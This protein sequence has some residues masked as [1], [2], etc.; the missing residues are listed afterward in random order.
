MS[1]PVGLIGNQ[2]YLPGLSGTGF[3]APPFNSDHTGCP[4]SLYSVLAD[5]ATSHPA[6]VTKTVSGAQL[7]TISRTARAESGETTAV[8]SS[9]YF[10]LGDKSTAATHTFFIKAVACDSAEILAGPFTITVACDQSVVVPQDTANSGSNTFAVSSY[11]RLELVDWFTL[12][13]TTKYCPITQYGVTSD[14]TGP[15]SGARPVDGVEMDNTCSQ[16]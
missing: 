2:Q 6:F 11:G 4:V 8:A 5:N 14:P 3:V 10:E 16:T 9:I 12:S 1:A 13:T 7:S 15:T